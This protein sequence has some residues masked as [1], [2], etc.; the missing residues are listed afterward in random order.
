MARSRLLTPVLAPVAV[1]VAAVVTLS[2]CGKMAADLGQQ[3]VDVTFSQNATFKTIEHVAAAC[4]D[5]PNVHADPL[6]KQHTALNLQAGVRYDTTNA[7]VANIAELQQCVEKFSSV[8]GF[9]PG[10]TGDDGD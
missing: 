6:P 3:W 5:V 8:Q 1:A 10:D 7:T 2:G 9:S 4:S